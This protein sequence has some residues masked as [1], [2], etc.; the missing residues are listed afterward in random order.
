M[1]VVVAIIFAFVLVFVIPIGFLMSTTIAAG[2]LGELLRLKA[3]R[4]HAD[5]E[6]LDTNY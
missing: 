5:S 6:L 3:E 1:S 2:T 4:D